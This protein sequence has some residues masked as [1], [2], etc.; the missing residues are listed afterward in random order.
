MK[1]VDVLV[2]QLLIPLKIKI[3]ILIRGVTVEA[4]ILI[5]GWRR[6]FLLSCT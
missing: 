3:V 1:Y 2:H 5:N 4:D 6:I